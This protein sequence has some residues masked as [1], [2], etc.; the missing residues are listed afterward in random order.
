MS[1]RERTNSG[2]TYGEAS[3]V[4]HG[5]EDTTHGDKEHLI[6]KKIHK[7]FR[8]SG[9]PNVFNKYNVKVP[10]GATL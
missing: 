3:G 2:F 7:R 8:E 4:N 5:R 1:S 10:D 6:L 9:N